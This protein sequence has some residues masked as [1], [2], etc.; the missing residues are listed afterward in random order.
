MNYV[1]NL[2]RAVCILILLLI[3]TLA[4][5]EYKFAE[6]WSKADT[7][8]E[9]TFLAVAAVDWAQTHWAAKH[10]FYWDGHQHD[11]TNIFLGSRPSTGKVDTLI[12][13]GMLA[14]V[15][16]AMALPSKFEVYDSNIGTVNINF[17][18]IWQCTWIVGEVTAVGINYSAGIRLEW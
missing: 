8:W 12:P 4:N 2:N 1:Q 7:A 3:P 15:A 10:D 14:H 6:N 9:C 16:I 18:R 11:E 13:L 17:R 5:A